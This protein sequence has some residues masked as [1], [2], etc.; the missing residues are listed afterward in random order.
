[1]A[2][3]NVSG[4]PQPVPIR[5]PPQ[6][7]SSRSR[8]SSVGQIQIRPAARDVVE[9]VARARPCWGCTRGIPWLTSWLP[10]GRGTTRRRK[11]R[12][13]GWRAGA[14]RSARAGSCPRTRVRMSPRL[15]RIGTT[16]SANSS[17]PD[18]STAGMM[19][20]PSAAPLRAPVL[21]GVRD[22]LRRAREGPVAAAA[23][24][25]ADQLPD[26][27]PLPPGELDDQRVAALRAL[28]LILGRQAV[29][30]RLVQRELVGGR[31]RAGGPAGHGP[32]RPGSAGRARRR[33]PSPRLRSSRA[34]G[35]C[36]AGS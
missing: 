30:Q 24:E 28:D 18:G 7:W 19:L 32:A 23:A 20:N 8:A 35:R 17:R 9:A 11:R 15:R 2:T 36:R 31:A 26:G 21:D 27:Q 13:T 25:P 33:V 12:R 22:L 14:G 16:C 4:R 10:P 34:P 6:P 5:A 1:M 29:R 3:V